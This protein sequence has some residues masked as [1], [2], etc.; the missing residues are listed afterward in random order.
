MMSANGYGRLLFVFFIVTAKTDAVN[1]FSA[2]FLKV[3]GKEFLRAGKVYN[4]FLYSDA[5]C[6]TIEL[7]LKGI[8]C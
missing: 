1:V 5:L 7:A 6:I 3:S 2:E 8:E 4:L